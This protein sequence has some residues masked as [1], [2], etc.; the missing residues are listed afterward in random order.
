M[1]HPYRTSS[2]SSA[3]LSFEPP[4]SH[5]R[6]LIRQ[7][8][9]PHL[10]TPLIWTTP[11]ALQACHPPIEPPALADTSH[12][13]HPYRTS[14]LSS[15]NGTTRTCRHL[16]FGAPLSHFRPPIRQLKH[17][18]CRH[19]SFGP[20][21]SQFK[22]LIHQLRHTHLQAPLNWFTPIALQA[23]HPPIEPPALANTSHLDH[24]H[25]TSGLSSAN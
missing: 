24:P 10:Q 19:I 22:P 14:G 15:A 1:D 7:L 6:H 16:S 9:Y 11:I 21:L 12:L 2:L 17:P 3:H 23:S 20:P 4:L 18:P 25:H 8:N 13:D 5:F